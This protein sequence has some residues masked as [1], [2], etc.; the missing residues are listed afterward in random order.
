MGDACPSPEKVPYRSQRAARDALK[1]L[2]R[3]RRDGYGFLHV[4]RCGG[5]WHVGHGHKSRHRQPGRR[6][7]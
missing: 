6:F 4:Y 7:R 3:N 1:A 2:K 5:H